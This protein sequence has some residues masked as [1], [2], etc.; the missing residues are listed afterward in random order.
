MVI[1][2]RSRNIAQS[3]RDTK[4]LLAPFSLRLLIAITRN[5]VESRDYMLVRN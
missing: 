5:L 4:S 3:Y 1:R 2:F